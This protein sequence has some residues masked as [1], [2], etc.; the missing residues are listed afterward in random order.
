MFCSGCI[1]AHMYIYIHECSSLLANLH[2]SLIVHHVHTN[3][4]I[5]VTN[6]FTCGPH[7][8]PEY[9]IVTSTHPLTLIPRSSA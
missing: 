3:D 2:W 8:V 1:E 7:L 5:E 9:S 6:L 4:Y